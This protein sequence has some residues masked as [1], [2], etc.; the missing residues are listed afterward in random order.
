MTYD[1]SRSVDMSD[2][3][4]S[5]TSEQNIAIYNRK[6]SILSIQKPGPG[7]K[8]FNERYKSGFFH[9]NNITI[10]GVLKWRS[11][12]LGNAKFYLLNPAWANFDPNISK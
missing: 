4:T 7:R 8:N 3:L 11:D 5:D 12:C 6:Q 10:A 9:E 1:E 2:A